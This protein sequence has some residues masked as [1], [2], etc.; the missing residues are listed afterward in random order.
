MGFKAPFAREN[1]L[2]FGTTDLHYHPPNVSVHI[3]FTINSVPIS[4]LLQK[5]RGGVKKA[6]RVKPFFVDTTADA[7][8]AILH[9][10]ALQRALQYPKSLLYTPSRA[11]ILFDAIQMRYF[12]IKKLTFLNHPHIVLQHCEVSAFSV[13][14]P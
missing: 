9:P 5:V 2:I 4:I 13:K 10:P 1:V 8:G 12:K 6:F 7:S 3:P 14:G 11:Q